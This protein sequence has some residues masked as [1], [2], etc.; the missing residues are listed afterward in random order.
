MFG[1]LVSL[2]RVGMWHL[3]SSI[4]QRK[5]VNS[6]PHIVMVVLKNCLSKKKKRFWR[7]DGFYRIS[8]PHSSPPFPHL[9]SLPHIECK[10]IWTRIWITIVGMAMGWDGTKGWG[11]HPRSAWFCLALSLPRP[12]PHDRENFFT[13]SLPLGARRSPVP[14]RKT[15]LFVNFSYN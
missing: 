3:T 12:I 5:S 9:S 8:L 7:T 6:A 13:P 11:L 4:I 14:P 10:Q 2:L 1:S 15:Q